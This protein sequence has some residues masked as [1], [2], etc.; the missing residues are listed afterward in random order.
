MKAVILAV[1]SS[2]RVAREVD[3]FGGLAVLL[4]GVI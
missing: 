1:A 4:P 2:L 3:Y